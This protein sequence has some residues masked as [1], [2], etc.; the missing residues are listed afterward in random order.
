MIGNHYA[1]RKVLP[2]MKNAK[3]GALLA[4]VATFLCCAWAQADST[5]VILRH[6]EKPPAGLGQLS[7]Q[8]LNRSLALPRVLLA[9]YGKPAAI[10]A[11]NPSIQKQ[12]LGVPYAYI[13]PLATIEP[14]AIQIGMPVNVSWGMS[15]IE[16]LAETLLS[17]ADGLQLVAW[18]HHLGKELAKLL[19]AKSGGNKNLVPEWAGDD[20]DSL[21]VVR[22]A[23]GPDG[24]KKVSFSHEQQGLNSMPTACPAANVP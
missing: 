21:Y 6:G 3:S 19:L 9:R 20:F 11:P 12:D 8:G 23:S 22:I 15:D 4:I 7:C 10:Y 17:K 24:A 2:F 13:R 5:I 1:C 16:P 14:L 18:E